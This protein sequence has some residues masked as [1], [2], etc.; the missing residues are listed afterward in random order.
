MLPCTLVARA[1]RLPAGQSLWRA[2]DLSEPALA[3]FLRTAT[4]R[5]DLAR[6]VQLF[7]IAHGKYLQPR[8]R[9]LQALSPAFLP[10]LAF[11][12]NVRTLHVPSLSDSLQ[13]AFEVVLTSLQHLE[14]WCG[15]RTVGDVV[16]LLNV[17]VTPSLRRLELIFDMDE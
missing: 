13:P 9:D 2:I 6:K 8:H 7:A 10:A 16:E 5:P 4:V 15:G 3:P 17:N 11:C 12:T 1:W 14:T